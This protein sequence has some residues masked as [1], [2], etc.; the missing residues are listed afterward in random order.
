MAGD[1]ND[2]DWCEARLAET[3]PELAV[4]VRE[5]IA[6]APRSRLPDRLAHAARRALARAAAGGNDRD[7][8]LDLLAAD[9][10]VTL[11]LA[12]QVEVDVGGLEGFAARLRW[13]EAATG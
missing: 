6:V 10:L 8:A 2:L 5:F 7:A 11:A 9:G 13:S 4:R 12:A 3:P 1:L